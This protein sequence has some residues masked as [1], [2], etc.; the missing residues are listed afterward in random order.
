MF[1]ARASELLARSLDGDHEP[2]HTISDCD[3]AVGDR[4]VDIR[5]AHKV[6]CAT[7]N[8]VGEHQ[9]FSLYTIREMLQWGGFDIRQHDRSVAAEFVEWYGIQI[10]GPPIWFRP[11][12]TRRFWILF[13]ELGVE[14][15]GCSHIL[16]FISRGQ[17]QLLFD[18]VLD[19]VAV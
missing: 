19:V 18:I 5:C 14:D 9:A 11:C 2:T 12:A 7:K 3:D 4:F 17:M 8:M 6:N 15:V 13:V 1:E 16:K 10:A